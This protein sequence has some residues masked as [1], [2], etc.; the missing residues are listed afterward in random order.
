VAK[1]TFIRDNFYTNY[2]LYIVGV[3]LAWRTMTW[4]QSA[5]PV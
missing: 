2:Y 1:D 5:A 3:G 4:S